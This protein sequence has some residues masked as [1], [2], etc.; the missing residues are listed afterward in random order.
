DDLEISEE[1]HLG[2]Y[3]ILQEH[4]TNITRYADASL[5]DVSLHLLDE[6]LILKVVDDGKGFDP[7]G[8]SNGIGITNMH[9]RAKSMHGSLK[10]NSAPGLGCVLIA[11]FPLESVE[12]DM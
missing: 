12:H 5:V 1:L 8:K 7:L 11:T 9:S 4:L 10:I 3:R 2:L 6:H